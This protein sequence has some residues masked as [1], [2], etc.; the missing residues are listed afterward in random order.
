MF[1]LR[2]MRGVTRTLSSS[3]SSDIIQRRRAAFI[4]NLQASNHD[5]ESAAKDE[6]IDYDARKT[7]VV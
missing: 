5:N 3:K 1:E 4:D 6:K 7:G 2:W